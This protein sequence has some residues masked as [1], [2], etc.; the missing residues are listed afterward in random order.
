LDTDKTVSEV[1]GID[2]LFYNNLERNTLINMGFKNNILAKKINLLR[3][4]EKTKVKLTSLI[5]KKNNL[6]ILDEP[7]NHL[8]LMS[9][10]QLEETLLDYNGTILLVSHDRY[11]LKK[12]CSSLLVFSNNKITKLECSVD[13][14][15]DGTSKPSLKDIKDRL[16]LIENRISF[17]LGEI[18]SI[19]KRSPE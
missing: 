19:D 16:I 8:D 4:G 13:E 12:L 10:E 7:H 3:P 1:L 5:L 9:R 6:L 15:I 17:I 18:S 14:Y 2:D 11:M